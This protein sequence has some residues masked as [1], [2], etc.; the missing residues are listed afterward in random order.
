MSV[1]AGCIHVKERSSAKH[2]KEPMEVNVRLSNTGVSDH[3]ELLQL[4][5]EMNL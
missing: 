2:H 4:L 5:V 1:G 3:R